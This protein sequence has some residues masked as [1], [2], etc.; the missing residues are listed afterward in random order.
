ML[1]CWLFCSA[2]TFLFHLSA[3]PIGNFKNCIHRLPGVSIAFHFV[4][5]WIYCRKQRIFIMAFA[6]SYFID[7][8]I[9]FPFYEKHIFYVDLHSTFLVTFWYPRCFHCWTQGFKGCVCYV[10]ASLFCKSKGEHLRNKQDVFYFTSKA[11][12][13]L[14]IIKF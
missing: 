1:H 3:T 4:N 10:C 13:F 8:Q 12:F 7:G 11:L 9:L 5:C 6:S 2:N 14:G